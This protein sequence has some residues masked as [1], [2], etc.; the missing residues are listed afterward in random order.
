M[1]GGALRPVFLN[2]TQEQLDGAYDQSAWAPEMAALEAQDG[3]ASA[4]LRRRMPARTKRYGPSEAAVLSTG[5]YPRLPYPLETPQKPNQ[6]AR[7]SLRL[8]NGVWT[9]ILD[10]CEMTDHGGER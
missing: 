1:Q 5:V 6:P 2:Y 9:R 4:A 7:I 3:E 10:M 8:S